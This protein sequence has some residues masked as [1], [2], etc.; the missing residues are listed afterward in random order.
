MRRKK[1][2]K[3]L[4]NEALNV[5]SHSIKINLT[6]NND[7]E[8]IISSSNK[9]KLLYKAMKGILNISNEDAT[10]KLSFIEVPSSAS[11]LIHLDDSKSNVEVGGRNID[12]HLMHFQEVID[13][14]VYK[15]QNLQV[16]NNKLV[17][18]VKKLG[19]ELNT[20]NEVVFFF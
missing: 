17:Q 5:A 8:H 7:H 20:I 3:K 2:H 13:R 11:T 6:K 16:E 1:G 10:K 9:L 14:F 4:S 18:Q 19:V 15:T 12:S